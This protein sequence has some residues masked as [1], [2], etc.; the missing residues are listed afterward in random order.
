MDLELTQTDFHGIA[1]V[2]V[3]RLG[4]DA[5]KKRGQ[6]A[7]VRGQSRAGSGLGVSN[8]QASAKCAFLLSNPDGGENK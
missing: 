6:F 8:Y 5:V 3:R 1:G 4:R 7:T 2:R